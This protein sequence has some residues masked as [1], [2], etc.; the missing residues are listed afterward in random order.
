MGS[1][2]LRL[3]C[4]I[5]LALV[6]AC[7]SGTR[8][9]EG[10]GSVA[11]LVSSDVLPACPSKIDG[12]RVF[13]GSI[14]DI[15]AADA[16][17]ECGGALAGAYGAYVGELMEKADCNSP[18]DPSNWIEQRAL[19]ECNRPW[20]GNDDTEVSVELEAVDWPPWYSQGLA[21]AA[22]RHL[23]VAQ[24]L[25]SA[26]LSRV[27]WDT[28]LLT[29]A[30]RR[31][32]LEVTRVEAEAAV[33]GYAR[34][35]LVLASDV[36]DIGEPLGIG[37]IAGF[38]RWAQDKP[39]SYFEHL[40]DD[41]LTA[42]DLLLILD[43]EMLEMLARTASARE[44]Y[45]AV[46]PP[47]ELTAAFG[48]PVTANQS[49]ELWGPGSWR[50]RVQSLLFGH[51]ALGT[52]GG[53]PWEYPSNGLS[54]QR[55]RIPYMRE[56]L[57]A[58]EVQ[59]L[60][61]LVRQYDALD[62]VAVR[63]DDVSGVPLSSCATVER[64]PT[65]DRIYRRVEAQIRNTECQEQASGGC[66]MVTHADIAPG[67]DIDDVYHSF[68]IWQKYRIAPEH[69][70]HFAAG[71]SDS[72][73]PMSVDASA[74]C[75]PYS[76]ATGIDGRIAIA[77]A[78]GENLEL[79]VDATSNG[80]NVFPPRRL[81]DNASS[82]AVSGGY[83]IPDP[84][85]IRSQVKASVE[86][87]NHVARDESV[88]A[89]VA[90]TAVRE[91]LVSSRD[92]I[93]GMTYGDGPA[94]LRATS[95]FSDSDRMLDLIRAA[96][97]DWSGTIR[98]LPTIEGNAV[99]PRRSADGWNWEADL[100]VTSDSGWPFGN[101]GSCM[102]LLA[103]NNTDPLLHN[104]VSYP[105]SEAFGRS[106]VDYIDKQWTNP[107]VVAAG[108]WVCAPAWSNGETAR[109]RLPVTI[110]DDLTGGSLA[111]L[112]WLFF[113]QRRD[114]TPWDLPS[115]TYSLS[116]LGGWFEMVNFDPDP[117]DEW[118]TAYHVAG[119]GTLG[120]SA[121]RVLTPSPGDPRKPAFDAFGF[122]TDWVPPTNSLLAGS[123]SSVEYRLGNARTAAEQ[124]TEAVKVALEGLIAEAHDEAAA[125]VGAKERDL[126]VEHIHREL[127]GDGATCEVDIEWMR[128]FQ[129]K[130]W[131]SDSECFA[132]RLAARM[133]WDNRVPIPHTDTMPGSSLNTAVV[134]LHW[135]IAGME[136]AIEA[137]NM[138]AVAMDAN[139]AAADAALAATEEL[140]RTNCSSEAMQEA[141]EAGE[142]TSSGWSLG[143]SCSVGKSGGCGPSAG[144]SSG[145]SYSSAPLIQQKRR[146]EEVRIGLGPAEAQ[147]VAAMWEGSAALAEQCVRMSDRAGQVHI[148]S[149]KVLELVS[150][151]Q[152]AEEQADL[153][154]ELQD[155]ALTTTF[156]LYKNY[157]AYDLWRANALLESARRLA[158][159]ARR[160]I[161]AYYVV[162]LSAM[163]EQEPFVAPPAL[164]ADEV[165]AY[166]LN[167]P[168]AVGLSVVT[169]D[170]GV[171]TG[172]Y[173]NRLVDYVHNLEMF[174]AGYPVARPTADAHEDT[175][176]VSLPGLEVDFCE[177]CPSG[178][179]P[180]D[181]RSLGWRFWCEMEQT[182][183]S[184]P[185]SGRT[186]ELC[187]ACDPAA[188]TPC[189]T[190]EKP[191]KASM[192]FSL[193]PWGRP[194]NTPA[195]EPY[196]HRH[197]VRWRRFAVNFVG[198]GVRACDQA[199]DPI[200]CYSEPVVRYDL[201]HVGPAWV[202][203]YS[204][205]WH[206]V[207]IER[208]YVEGAKALAA[209]LWLD[210]VS[211][212]WNQP[213]VVAVGRSE[214]AERPIAGSYELVFYL[215][216]EV[217]LERVERVQLLVSEDYWVSQF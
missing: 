118:L 96:T 203:D 142:S 37:T 210:S 213:E 104:F 81:H 155:I 165:Y 115:R 208:A 179:K 26:A 32:L 192:D 209:E 99:V 35:G 140:V 76:G 212:G 105:N 88:G 34:I 194:Y 85:E 42:L 74:W 65:A 55:S 143:G 111:S 43:K 23:C 75:G 160:A 61:G 187:S 146:C 182:W 56:N 108:Q 180:L 202:A 201:A 14:T 151:A 152:M 44:D 28:I 148:T 18:N 189:Q 173:P 122:R 45:G 167:M 69:A 95:F 117:E 68:R 149:R 5:V 33:L 134:E 175:E 207:A 36:D 153:N 64:E 87:G 163:H 63:A 138:A 57:S 91:A 171:Q 4:V 1:T 211:A 6:A 103:A 120:L 94:I 198:T 107:S 137:G 41:F 128:L 127:C 129:D 188:E 124:A 2:K 70:R 11:S 184:L 145:T 52:W 172:I 58:P 110:N 139:V 205:E 3:V 102:R 49:D 50:Q 24:K 77:N 60:R 83:W 51:D 181:P 135:A 215:G 12:E 15:L 21:L 200:V 100:V 79:H 133:F 38:L 170:D 116:P 112:R 141:M 106:L 178:T 46:S 93:E 66:V 97:G 72:L 82:F 47:T 156:G 13:A 30:D 80:Q 157:H 86:G 101:F 206:S 71:V 113:V 53:E 158:L 121:T 31:K 196:L 19:P 216:P 174:V 10:A 195:D 67:L 159:M 217:Q 168:S 176:V 7:S 109:W 54:V 126:V 177:S 39:K 214:F 147:A 73:D 16:S 29:A 131:G 190:F 197:N 162:D 25:R 144:Y 199:E 59:L 89:M 20:L 114:G 17:A 193:D 164:W 186:D 8:P 119:G 125:S 27:A 92:L 48:I 150:Q 183:K 98:Q 185:A 123:P 191:T 204:L 90:L 136:A 40:G 161:E 62:V 132:S 84:R 9:E 130:C 78:S 169:P 22:S 154:A 166:D